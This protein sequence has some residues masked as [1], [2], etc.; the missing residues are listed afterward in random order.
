MNPI[1]KVM[2]IALL[3]FVMAPAFAQTKSAA[4]AAPKNC[5]GEWFSVFR[6]R[7]AKEIPD[8]TQK[9]IITLRDGSTSHCFMGKVEVAAGKIKLPLMIQ[10]QD[11]S[12]ETFASTGKTLDPSFTKDISADELLTITDG[13]SVTFRTTD[14][15]M[16]RLFFY[17]FLAEKPK[18]NKVAPPP[19]ALINK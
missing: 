16:G 5:Y 2:V 4:P 11:G 1:K 9:V 7:G 6:S 19:S 12:F 18:A 8:G 14:Q 15:E 13:M 10:K 3:V 17:E